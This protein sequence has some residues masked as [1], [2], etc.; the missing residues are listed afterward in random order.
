MPSPNDNP[1]ATRA[2][3]VAVEIL[4]CNEGRTPIT[5]LIAL[6]YLQGRIEAALELR[7]E[8]QQETRSCLT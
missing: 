7:R 5:D 4:T 1:A 3:D 6:G 2:H 8:R